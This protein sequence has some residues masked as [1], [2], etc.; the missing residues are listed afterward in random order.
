[1]EEHA[2]DYLSNLMEAFEVDE[3]AEHLTEAV[4][5]AF[6]RMQLYK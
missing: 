5:K 1:M 4:K 6:N 2:L 3:I